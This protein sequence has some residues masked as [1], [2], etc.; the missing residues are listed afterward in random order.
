MNYYNNLVYKGGFFCNH[1]KFP[2][3]VQI[4]IYI[5]KRNY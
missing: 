2:K 3:I 4:L 5:S 1:K